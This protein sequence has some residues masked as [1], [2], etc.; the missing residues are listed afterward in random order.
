M[1]SANGT[2]GNRYEHHGEYGVLVIFGA[3][4]VPDLRQLGTVH[5]Q[6]HHDTECH[7]Q[8][9]CTEY[10]IELTY[11]LV[12]GEQCCN[13]V[14]DEYYAYPPVHAQCSGSKTCQDI[15]RL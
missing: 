15:G 9:S 14:V 13:Q 8:Q 7:K 1:E 6:S 10:G 4:S 12:N 11:D 2:A 5:E 3:E